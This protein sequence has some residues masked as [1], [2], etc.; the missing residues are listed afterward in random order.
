MMA[1]GRGGDRWMPKHADTIAFGPF[2]LEPSRRTLERDGQPVAVSARAFDILVE[3]IE[4]RDRTVGRE[5]LVAQVWPGITVEPSNLTVQMS[6]LRRALG[7]VG[8]QPSWIATIPGRGYRF[9]GTV[10]GDEAAASMDT[11]S[12]A[13]TTPAASSTLGSGASR[14]GRR[15]RIGW[16]VPVGLGLA[17]MAGLIALERP[18]PP[19][20]RLSVVVMPFRNL[21]GNASQDFLADAISDDL[22]TDLS[23]LPGSL[24]IARQSADSYRGRAVSASEVGRALHVHYLLE[25]SLRTEGASVHINAQ[26]IDTTTEAHLWAARFDTTPD[27]LG[28]ARNAIVRRIASALDVVLTDAEVAAQPP[29]DAGAQDL[30]LRARS[31]SRRDDTMAGLTAAQGLLERAVAAQPDYADALALLGWVLLRKYQEFDDAEAGR[32]LARADTVISHALALVPRAAL[33]NAA[34]GRL[35]AARGRCADAKAAFDTALSSDPNS[36]EALGG[37]AVCAWLTGQVDQAVL[38]VQDL[39][40]VDPEGA[41]VKRRQQLLGLAFLFGGH[42]REAMDALLASDTAEPDRPGNVESMTPVENGRLYL[43]AASAMAGDPK[44]AHRRY[45]AYAQV[46]PG[47]TVWRVLSF[48]TRAQA[49]LPASA[50]IETALVQAG[51][52]RFAAQGDCQLATAA[53]IKEGDF[54]PTPSELAGGHVL[55]TA[56]VT[57]L[58]A[59]SPSPLIVDLG[60]GRAAIAGSVRLVPE[61]MMADRNKFAAT[62][63]GRRIENAPPS[64]QT[65]IMSDGAC[66]TASY[67]AALH[68]VRLGYR[69]IDWYRGGEEAWSLAGR[70]SIDLRD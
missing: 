20:A 51:M 53:P 49:N 40:A 31:V 59:G 9:I 48:L 13:D 2:R 32:D 18:T 47:R 50:A 17:A 15:W 66:G 56:A 54:T 6:T 55:D 58:L 52:P 67:L 62:P 61:D 44:E 42:A 63:L 46:W 12:V 4:A 1:A 57:Q 29:G 65:I 34:R 60:I 36:T 7:D 24:V 19:H 38:A 64:A 28:E 39:L 26:L 43:I 70:P 69:N 25:G 35:L 27:R 16:V 30:F 10:A 11:P 45:L 41:L 14:S 21:S 37:R 5:E 23:K 33:A 22:T 8:P 3:L 68:L